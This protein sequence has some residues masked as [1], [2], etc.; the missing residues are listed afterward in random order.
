VSEEVKQRFINKAKAA[1]FDTDDLIFV[2]QKS[3]K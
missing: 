3:L 1:G 2:K